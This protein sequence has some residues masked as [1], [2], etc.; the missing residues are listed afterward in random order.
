MKILDTVKFDE[1]GLAPAIVQDSETGEVLMLAYMNREALERTIRTGKSHFYS[2]ARQQLWC[3]GETSGHVQSVE[4]IRADCDCDT[5]LLRV[6]QQGAACH[7]GYRSC[8]FRKLE[9]ASHWKVTASRVFDPEEVYR[10]K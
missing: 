9:D 7:E 6:R 1:K 5:I 10:K 8:F 4:E 3:K 2:R